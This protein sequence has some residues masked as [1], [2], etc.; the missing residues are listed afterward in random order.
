MYLKS[1][2]LI[3]FV[4]A[5]FLVQSACTKDEES[6]KSPVKGEDSAAADQAQDASAVNHSPIYF[7]FDS[8][9]VK[10]GYHDQVMKISESLKASKAT[11]QV[12]GHCDERGTTEYNLALGSRRAAE[13]KNTLVQMGVEE[14]KVSTISYGK[15]RPEVEG[16]DEG[17][18]SKNRRAEFR[19]NR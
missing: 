7:D 12:E 2:K 15:E 8:A 4:F 19:V 13:V 14:T 18:W 10:D 11:V 6:M 17:A 1:K 5:S 16:H 3:A 9:L